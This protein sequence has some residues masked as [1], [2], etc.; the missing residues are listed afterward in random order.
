MKNGKVVRRQGVVDMRVA[1]RNSVA[2]DMAWF[3]MDHIN[4]VEDHQA[5][6]DKALKISKKD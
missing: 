3:R 6:R 1:P 2:Q 4:K 5:E